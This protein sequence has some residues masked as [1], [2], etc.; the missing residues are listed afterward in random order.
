MPNL[1]ASEELFH[2][3]RPRSQRPGS[4]HAGGLSSCSNNA[5]N[6]AGGSSIDSMP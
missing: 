3:C 6:S 1:A 4:Y 2:S 5:M